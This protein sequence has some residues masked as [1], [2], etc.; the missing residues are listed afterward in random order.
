[1]TSERKTTTDHEEIRSWVEEHG[2]LPAAVKNTLAGDAAGVL[3]LDFPGADKKDVA[4]MTWEQFFKTFD[5]QNLALAYEGALSASDGA[6][7]WQ[8]V[9][10][11]TGES[12]MA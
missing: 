1:M 9:D 6:P 10:R 11:A 8:L 2:G 4:E 3:Y 5:R 7:S 12:V